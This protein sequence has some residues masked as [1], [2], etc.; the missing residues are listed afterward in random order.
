MG[1][2]GARLLEIS[3]RHGPLSK[4]VLCLTL[5]RLMQMR[6]DL[7]RCEIIATLGPQSIADSNLEFSSAKV[8]FVTWHRFG[9]CFRNFSI[10]GDEDRRWAKK[11]IALKESSSIQIS[12]RRWCTLRNARG[13]H[14]RRGGAVRAVGKPHESN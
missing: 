4:C 5:C 14:T 8:L 7:F 9:K 3:L 6:D 13:H 2:A 12:F 10:E 1:L 11:E